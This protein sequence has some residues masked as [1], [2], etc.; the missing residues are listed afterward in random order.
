MT[1]RRQ[2]SSNDEDYTIIELEI[3]IF[4][5]AM[6]RSILISIFLL[7]CFLGKSQS[8]RIAR[9]SIKAT[10][11]NN[12]LVV[13]T[14][15]AGSTC[16]SLVVERSLD[17]INFRPVY[18]YPSVCGDSDVEVSY[19]WTD[20]NPQLYAINYYRLNLDDIEFTIPIA[21]D[22]Q[23]ILQGKR[24]ITYPNPSSGSLKVELRNTENQNFDVEIFDNHGS[25]VHTIKS[26]SGR[27]YE[28]NLADRENGI[29]ALKLTFDNKETEVTHFIIA[30]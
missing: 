21:I 18:T 1:N 8:P 10:N 2:S 14:M 6:V 20:T 27:V 26:V 7:S 3:P 11:N 28:L 29:Y 15:N 5:F 16:P 9:H 23:S 25:L 22:L 19:S 13:W 30:R 17:N 4:K 12:V 24:I